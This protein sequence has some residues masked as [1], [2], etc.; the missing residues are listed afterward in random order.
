ML[1]AEADVIR[2][3][4][5]MIRL[6]STQEA[7]TS[8]ADVDSSVLAAVLKLGRV[9]CEYWRTFSILSVGCQLRTVVSDDPMGGQHDHCRRK[10]G[11][12]IP[13]VGFSQLPS[14]HAEPSKGE[15]V[16]GGAW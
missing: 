12:S 15:I 6:S 13:R 8:P 3:S 10:A 2:S 5:T 16:L 9:V 1:V 7:D 14:R 4:G 11:K